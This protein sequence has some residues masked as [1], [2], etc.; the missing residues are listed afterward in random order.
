M[1]GVLSCFSRHIPTLPFITVH[2]RVMK[3][4]FCGVDP[5]GQGVSVS[6]ILAAV[7]LGLTAGVLRLVLTLASAQ[8][9]VRIQT[10][11]WNFLAAFCQLIEY[12]QANIHNLNLPS[13]YTPEHPQSFPQM[14]ILIHN[15]AYG[16]R[17]VFT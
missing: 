2:M 3:F 14:I 1:L 5:R 8:L 6:C 15:N 17:H 7:V 12:L 10:A 11:G 9:C 16:E 13:D 4:E